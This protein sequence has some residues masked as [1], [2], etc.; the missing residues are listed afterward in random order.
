[1]QERVRP[2]ESPRRVGVNDEYVMEVRNAGDVPGVTSQRA[3]AETVHVVREVSDDLLTELQGK[4][5]GG[6]RVYRGGLRRSAPGTY[7]LESG[8]TS[9]PES[10]E[11]ELNH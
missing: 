3:C 11:V 2:L 5:G 7:L 10:V 6:G 1:M 8:S 4:S 9:I